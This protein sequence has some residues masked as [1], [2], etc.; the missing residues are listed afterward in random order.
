MQ[1]NKR[2]VLSK[3]TKMM[4]RTNSKDGTVSLRIKR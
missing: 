3:V 4:K 1:D 2:M